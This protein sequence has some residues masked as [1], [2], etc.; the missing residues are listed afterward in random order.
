M[1]SPSRN[2]T[3]NADDHC[4]HLGKAGVCRYLE[5]N[6]VEG[7]RWVCGLRRVLRSW[8][9]VHEDRR[10]RDNIKPLLI[11]AGVRVDCGDWPQNDPTAMTGQVGLC[12]FQGVTDG[13]LG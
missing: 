4:C 5:E 13:D 9:R 7:R 1:T 6:T 3:G 2:C 8:D 12:C 11:D 10:Y